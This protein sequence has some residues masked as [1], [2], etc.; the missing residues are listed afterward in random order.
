MVA[1]LVL[2]VLSG[3]DGARGGVAALAVTD[4]QI[5]A[6]GPAM[7]LA[8][9][10]GRRFEPRT[11]PGRRA[12]CDVLAVGDSLWVCG[13]GGLLAV[14]RDHGTRWQQI[15]TGGEQ[16][17]SGLA[18]GADGAIWVVGDAGYAARV[19]GE[20]PRRVELGLGTEAGLAGVH[21]VRDEIVALGADGRVIRWREGAAAAVA[22]GAAAGLAGLAVTAKGTWVVVGAAGFV[23]RSPDGTWY[24]R[25]AAGTGED[26]AAIGALPD[27]TLVIAGAG[28]TVLCSTD[29]ARTWRPI[30]H[31]FGAVA[32][33]S[34][35]RYGRGLLIGGD[36]GLILQLAPASAPAPAPAPADDPQGERS[37]EPSGPTSGPLAPTRTAA[38]AGMAP[39]VTPAARLDTTPVARWA[40]LAWRW[41]DD[42]AAHRALIARSTQVG[43]AHRTQLA[44]VAALRDAS[45]AERAHGVAR[46]A[47]ELTSIV[48]AVLT[49]SL[50]RGDPLDDVLAT[51][52]EDAAAESDAAAGDGDGDG[53]GDDGDAGDGDAGDER[54]PGWAAIDPLAIIVTPSILRAGD[55]GDDERGGDDDR[56]DDDGDGRDGGGREPSNPAR[57]AAALAMT[58][59]ALRLHPDDEDVQFTHAMLLL[60]AER[61]GDPAQAEALRAA[62]SAFS[63]G[64][65]VQI[66]IRMAKLAHRWFEQAIELVLSFALPDRGAAGDPAHPAADAADS[67]ASAGATPVAPLGDIADELVEELGRAILARTPRHIGRLVPLLPDDAKLL[68]ELAQDADAAGQPEAALALYNRMIAVAIPGGGDQRISYLRAFNNACVQAHAAGAFEV[69]VRLAERAQPIAYENPHLYHAAACAYAAVHDHARALE[70]VKLAIAHHYENI[71]R[72][73][74]DTDLGPLLDWPQF[75]KLFRDWHARQEGN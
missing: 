62:M 33:R 42:G 19:L 16:R 58:A 8:S 68:C 50:L 43:P 69:A 32:L 2:S 28:G 55:T 71:A 61:A 22:C 41:L 63:L 46:L 34:V 9:P 57:I 37:G 27:G 25:V 1:E 49:G 35:A 3:S 4:Q 10:D 24:S 70:Q 18:L 48:E 15:E 17:L 30:A 73:E 45:D 65:R 52:V 14:S 6:V 75:K 56:D 40:E 74:T 39:A 5:V 66:A 29:D 21:A 7:V 13:E 44:A 60:D 20:A 64:T 26:L 36:A 31:A 72:I 67:A 12:L 23:A 47:G 38:P 51:L 59:R 53:D 11:A 54:A